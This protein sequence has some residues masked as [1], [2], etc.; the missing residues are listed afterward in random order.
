[1]PSVLITGASHG[2][3]LEF[4]RQY[5]ADGWRVI[6]TCRDPDR[7]RDLKAIAGELA[8][9][10]LDVTDEG[11]LD[12]LARRLEG[13]AIDVLLLNAGVHL[14]KDC[15]LAQLDPGLWLQELR[16][17][18]IAPLVVA[19]R[20]IDH[21][22]RSDQKRIIAISSG[23]GSISRTKTGG[24]YAYRTGKAALNAAMRTLAVDVAD[25]GITV[26][27]IGP[28]HTRTDMGGEDAPYSAQD[29]VSKVRATIARLQF[30]D[31]GSFLA[32]D[33]AHLPW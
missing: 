3:G 7:A 13:T 5:A 26:V 4:A 1:M 10:A 25:R 32:R 14:Q 30:E 16:V 11:A 12:E 17:N 33:G 31:S 22:S 2:L 8:T 19:R 28:G 23:A 24:N 15:T 29:S 27:S 9:H 21:V 6:A 20:F 18:A